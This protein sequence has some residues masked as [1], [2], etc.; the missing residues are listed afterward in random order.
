MKQFESFLAAHIQQFINYRQSLG[1]EI[2]SSRSHLKTFDRYL[3]DK[4]TEK[5]LLPPSFFLQLR[6]NLK[7]EPPFN[8]SGFLS[9]PDS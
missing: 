4:K 1:Y 9:I 3:M 2:S 5:T 6:S 8:A 7:I